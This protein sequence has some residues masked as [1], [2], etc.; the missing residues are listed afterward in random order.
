[1]PVRARL[2]R[3]LGAA[4]IQRVTQTEAQSLRYLD[5]AVVGALG[6]DQGGFG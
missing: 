2:I 4:D 1:M 3:S 6:I 5:I